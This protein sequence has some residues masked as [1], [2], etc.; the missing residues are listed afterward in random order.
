MKLIHLLLFFVLITTFETNGQNKFNPSEKTDT[1]K[2]QNV[3]FKKVLAY[4]INS[5]TILVSYEDFMK[6]FIPF[7]KRYQ[8]GAGEIE[9]DKEDNPWY[10]KR[11]KFLDATY[12]RLTTEIKTSDT[13]YIKDWDFAM[14]DIGT[15]Y[16]FV[17]RI[18]DGNC[19]VLD[20]KNVPQKIILRQYYS[21]QKGPLNGWGGWLYFIIGQ[22]ESFIERTR[23][24]S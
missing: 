8:K 12:K 21:Y 16:D 17:A 10:I 13:V 19:V 23:W 18:E 22:Q 5:V 3:T 2:L 15:G 20:N 4:K 6:S 1:V 9:R 11:F 7:W 24:I 14:A